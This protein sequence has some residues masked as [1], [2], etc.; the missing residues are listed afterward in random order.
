MGKL[1]T[2]EESFIEAERLF[3]L[4]IKKQEKAQN[5]FYERMRYNDIQ[6]GILKP[7]TKQI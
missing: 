7:T 2:L 5:D 1:P 6:K 3:Q 4:R